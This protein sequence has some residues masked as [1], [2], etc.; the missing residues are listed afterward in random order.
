[1]QLEDDWELSLRS[2]LPLGCS[3]CMFQ[4][5]PYIFLHIFRI[6]HPFTKMQQLTWRSRESAA[7]SSVSVFRGSK[8]VG[9]M[10]GSLPPYYEWKN[11]NCLRFTVATVKDRIQNQFYWLIPPFHVDGHI[12]SPFHGGQE[13]CT[14]CNY[15]NVRSTYMYQGS[16]CVTCKLHALC[17]T[18]SIIQYQAFTHNFYIFCSIFKRFQML[19]AST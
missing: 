7:T 19:L 17:S 5:K 18:D 14:R 1:M 9:Y 15:C 6:A 4:R 10:L 11:R 3:A 16:L 13:K 2:S 8:V 12:Y